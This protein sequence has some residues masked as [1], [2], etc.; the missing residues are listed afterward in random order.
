MIE[1]IGWVSSIILLM[2]LVKQVYKQWK[3]GSSEGISKW[4]FVGQLGASIGFT[5]YSIQTGSVIFAV[6]N[7]MLTINNLVGI[8]LY[9]RFLDSDKSSAACTKSADA[10]ES[11]ASARA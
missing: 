5:I 9:F 8:Y 10:R 3:E 4:L 2:T 11:S 6:T 7:S 1:I